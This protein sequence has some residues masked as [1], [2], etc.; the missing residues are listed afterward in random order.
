VHSLNNAHQCF[1]K[2]SSFVLTCLDHQSIY[3]MVL[4]VK[5][6]MRSTYASAFIIDLSR[7]MSRVCQISSVHRA[8]LDFA[9]HLNFLPY[10]QPFEEIE[11]KVSHLHHRVKVPYQQCKSR[12]GASRLRTSEMRNVYCFIHDQVSDA[13]VHLCMHYPAR[14]HDSCNK[15]VYIAAA[16]HLH[17]TIRE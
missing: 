15:A 6:G 9:L 13:P 12:S 16:Y 11:V 3:R 7:I 8:Q 17:H 10:C 4:P 5:G 2:A 1:S 14:Y